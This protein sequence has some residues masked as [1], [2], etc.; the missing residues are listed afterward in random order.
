MLNPS[1]ISNNHQIKA[2]ITCMAD[3]ARIGFKCTGNTILLSGSYG[4]QGGFTVGA[5]FDFDSDDDITAFGDDVDLTD[6]AF[7]AG[8]QNAVAL[9]AQPKFAQ[10]FGTSSDLFRPLSA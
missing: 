6:R 4:M 5:V 1:P 8:C 2:Q 9:Q 7:M 10:L 3:L